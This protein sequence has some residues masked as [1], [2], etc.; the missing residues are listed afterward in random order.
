MLSGEG[1]RALGA[2]EQA[3]DGEG[4]HRVLG[5]PSASAPVMSGHFGP[6]E[7]P[8]S[9]HVARVGNTTYD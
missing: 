8:D 6:P 4:C 7:G 9:R 3:F 2:C 1:I 5:S